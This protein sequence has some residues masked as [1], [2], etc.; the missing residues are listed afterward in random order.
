MRI[1]KPTV[2]QKL[3][4]TED[5]AYTLTGP[6]CD[7]NIERCK[8]DVEVDIQKAVGSFVATI[9]ASAVA[10]YIGEES[11]RRG[12]WTTYQVYPCFE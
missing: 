3:T 2:K 8:A 12:K 10:A 5:L 4:K 6:T 9:L 7:N 11:G 1:D